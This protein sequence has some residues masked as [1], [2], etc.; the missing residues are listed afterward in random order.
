MASVLV[1]VR[2][3]L[4]AHSRATLREAAR[5]A[6]ERDAAL[7]ILHVNLYQSGGSVS[8]RDLRQAVEDI[9]GRTDDV[10]CVV[11]Q[12]FLV[13]ETILE[14]AIVEDVD[15]VVIGDNQVGRW[16]RM[17]SRIFDDPDVERYLR[18]ELD[19][20]IITV[21]ASPAEK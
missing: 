4:T 12:G 14:E 7:T 3:P 13:E 19:S 10:R 2:Y 18:E 5:I 21:G 8:Q 11:R 1:P 20:E 15:A 9:L 16:R 6:D 17:I